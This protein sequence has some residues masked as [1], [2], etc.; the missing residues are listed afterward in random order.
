[1]LVLLEAQ[2]EN[3]DEI[4]LMVRAFQGA[5]M[6]LRYADVPVVVA[7][8]RAGARRRLRDRAARRPRSGGR[9]N[10]HRPRR[11]R[12]R[13]DP[14][15]RRAPRRCVRARPSRCRRGERPSAADP[16][17]LRDHRVCEGLGQRGRRQCGSATCAAVG[18]GHDEPRPAHRRRQGARTAACG[19]RL[20]AAGAAHGHSG[21]RRRR[22]RAA[23]ARHP[24]GLARRPHQRSRRADRPQA[25]DDHGRRRPA[26]SRHGRPSST[27]ST[28]SAKRFS[29]SRRA[30]RRR[31]AFSTR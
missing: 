12:R 22:A 13:P 18:R 14:G 6:A 31:S 4:D 5:T 30:A 23:E 28:S 7:P 29:A 20:S 21:G 2:E 3:W 25:G 11:G 24:P 15:R 19:R 26:A 17:R 1:M 16:A 9:R 27:C 10:L 8:G